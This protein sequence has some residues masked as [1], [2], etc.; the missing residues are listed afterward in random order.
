MK[1]YAA[2]SPM[3]NAEKSRQYR[4]DHLDY[5][6]KLAEQR[7]VFAKGRFTDSTGGLVIYIA[8]SFEEVEEIVKN[9]PYVVYGARGYDIHEWE[10]TTEAV[11][12][13]K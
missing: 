9:D 8:E 10:M 2:F 12:P 5:L 13:E 11:L 4:Q 3:K 1:Y 7:K 6:G